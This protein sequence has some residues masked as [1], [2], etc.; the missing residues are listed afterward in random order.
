MRYWIQMRWYDY[1]EFYDRHRFISWVLGICCFI[2][3][4]GGSYYGIDR[5]VNGESRFVEEEVA[6]EVVEV[7]EGGDGGAD[8]EFFDLEEP[9]V[10]KI[11]EI[12][13]VEESSEIV[14]GEGSVS[15]LLL[16]IDA[17]GEK[18]VGRSDTMIVVTAN[19]KDG[20]MRMVSI[21]RDS[22]VNIVGK[23]F[24]DKITHAYAFGGRDMAEATV[25]N[26]LGIEID[27]VVAANFN[28]FARVVD[29]VGGVTVDVPFDFDEKM[30][31]GGRAYF[32]KGEQTL[33]GDEALAYARMRKRDPRGDIGRNERQ[34][35]IIEALIMEVASFGSVPKIK[36]LYDVAKDNVETDVGALDVIGLIPYATGLGDVERLNIEGSGVM[37]NNIYYHQLNTGSLNSVREDLKGHLTK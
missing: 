30:V 10:A 16:G 26:L 8:I 13:T 11:E 34:Q 5:Y 32:T 29:I 28:S 12:E 3:V 36:D 25:E 23:G 17:Y 9:E 1:L 15:F 14:R 6:E 22:Y 7:A 31:S 19:K 20:S 35:Q 2:G 18:M 33:N 24:Y 37:I 21:P 27:H 4:V